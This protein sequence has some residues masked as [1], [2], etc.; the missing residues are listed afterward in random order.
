MD[1]NQTLSHIVCKYQHSIR[2]KKENLNIFITEAF[3]RINITDPNVIKVVDFYAEVKPDSMKIVL[4]GNMILITIEKQQHENW[5][6]LSYIGTK[7]DLNTRR[8]IAE[9]KRMTEL[10][11]LTEKSKKTTK[12]VK[13]FV[14]NK[15]IEIGDEQRRVLISK[16][17][18]EKNA[19]I[20]N[21]NEFTD[22]YNEKS[23][24]ER[25][26]KDKISSISK[27]NN[28][29]D[30]ESSNLFTQDSYNN[31][32][33]NIL[34]PIVQLEKKDVIKLSSTSN[35]SRTIDSIKQTATFN[36]EEEP[37]KIR[38]TK[39]YE[40]NLTKKLIPHYAARE[41]IAREPPMPKTKY[42]KFKG[43]KDQLHDEKNPLW[44]KEKADNFFNNKDYNSALLH[45]NKALEI[46]PEF[47]KV[48]VNIATCLLCMGNLKEAQLELV[49]LEKRLKENTKKCDKEDETFYQKLLIT[50]SSKLYAINAMTSSYNESFE[51]I[52]YLKK[53][54]HLIHSDFLEKINADEENILKRKLQE[55]Y[56]RSVK[57]EISSLCKNN[58]E[59][60]KDIKSSNEA[61]Y[62]KY[63]EYINKTIMEDNTEDKNENNINE[64]NEVVNAPL[65]Q[66]IVSSDN[67]NL[68]E[69]EI[70]I[71]HNLKK[72]REKEEMIKTRIQLS[73]LRNQKETD[74]FISAITHCS[75][76]SDN[77]KNDF[78]EQSD[79][80]EQI[81]RLSTFLNSYITYNNLLPN[82][83]ILSNLSLIFSSL[84]HQNI[85]LR[86][87]S[88]LIKQINRFKQSISY[89]KSLVNIEIKNLL[90]KAIAYEQYNDYE[91]AYQEI[92]SCEKLLLTNSNIRNK[93]NIQNIINEVKDKAKICLLEDNL[94]KANLLLI[95]K[96]FSD[97][98][99]VYNEC[100][101]LSYI[102]KNNLTTCK[103]LLNRSS[104]YLQLLQYENTI[105]D[106]NKVLYMLSKQ[107]AVHILSNNNSISSSGV[108]KK[109]EIEEQIKNIEFLALV[110][111]AS[112][113]NILKKPKEV[114]SCYES[115]LKIKEDKIIRENYQKIMF[116]LKSN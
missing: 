20:S 34:Q 64:N 109:K 104:C 4:E 18:Y 73:L 84:N 91:K 90:R 115:A 23:V 40:I 107:K 3:L 38:E 6:N 5:K 63:N 99:I 48:E 66:D 29:K 21:L 96:N 80:Q 85:V 45:Y 76:D 22:N 111:K 101:K 94:K 41:S 32:E 81:K 47:I 110:K 106:L 102:H 78:L 83:Q 10:K 100:M 37:I 58:K 98:L 7:D 113:M 61:V 1:W 39:T 53:Q 13:D 105:S 51:R 55:D 42:L 36:V 54:K 35:N 60:F 50:C 15:S 9:E 79:R 30:I 87:S 44:I 8:K 17:A 12:E 11:L 70:F 46:D 75:D 82:E 69:D 93:Q 16:K 62:E 57:N 97:A 33:K 89:N 71:N 49:K 95:G 19:E 108:E 24:I 27:E 25:R 14:I 116:N 31:Q 43:E 67:S 114:A 86:I 59:I 72:L 92:L 2:V 88:D 26:E 74:K 56:L 112:V 28:S 103:V 68:T 52:S 77:K 65:V